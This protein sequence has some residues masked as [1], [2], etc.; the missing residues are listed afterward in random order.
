MR[1]PL[2]LRRFRRSSSCATLFE[3][4]DQ[5]TAALEHLGLHIEFI[6]GGQIEFAQTGLQH[7]SKIALQIAPHRASR[8]RQPFHQPAGDVIDTDVLHCPF[9][10][11]LRYALRAAGLK[12]SLSKMV[13]T[14]G[15]QVMEVSDFPTFF[16]GTV[17]APSLQRRSR[18]PENTRT[19]T[20]TASRIRASII[21]KCTS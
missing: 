18:E 8:F 13:Q 7:R 9:P 20:G 3:L 12:S 19:R 17:S 6:A 10:R 2:G 15:R 1:S 14:R 5:R 4:R 21:T 11:L 16:H